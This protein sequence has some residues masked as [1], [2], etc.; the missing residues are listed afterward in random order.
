MLTDL[1]F[2]PLLPLKI[3][4]NILPQHFNF[5]Y[6]KK[7]KKKSQSGITTP[8]RLIFFLLHFTFNLRSVQEHHHQC[9]IFKNFDVVHRQRADDIQTE[10][11]ITCFS[12]QILLFTAEYRF[13]YGVYLLPKSMGFA[14]R[15]IS[16][17]Q[18]PF[19]ILTWRYLVPTSKETYPY[20]LQ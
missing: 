2:S 18:N 8:N 20:H 13:C 16:T 1:S 7:S 3:Y 15:F 4:S 9:S 12:Q 19:F 6:V 11:I 10:F 17:R 5:Y 14:M